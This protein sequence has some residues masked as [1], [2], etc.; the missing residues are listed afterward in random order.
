VLD[1]GFGFAYHA[2]IDGSH[3]FNWHLDRAH[4]IQVR[5]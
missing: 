2:Q 4:E 3:H 1:A 5:H